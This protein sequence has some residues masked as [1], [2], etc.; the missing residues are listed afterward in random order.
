MKKYIRAIRWTLLVQIVCSFLFVLA[1]AFVPYLRKLLFDQY[2]RGF[3]FIL[4]L[5]G[6]YLLLIFASFLFQY[7]SQVYEWKVDYRFS[8]SL[9]QDFFRAVMRRP[10]PVF[11]KAEVG[12]YTSILNNDIRELES[13]YIE[14]IIDIIKSSIMLAVY[15]SVMLFLVDVRITLVIIAASVLSAFLPK[16]TASRLSVRK[17]ASQDA[18]G[19][20]TARFQDLLG[21]YKLYNKRTRHAMEQTHDDALLQSEQ[22]KLAFGKFNTFTNVLNAFVMN[23]VHISAFLCVGWLL[24]RGEITLGTGAATFGYIESFIYPIQYILNDI[25]YINA[26]RSLKEKVLAYIETP[27]KITHAKKKDF[28]SIRFEGVCVAYK[29]FS[30]ENFTYAFEKGKRYAIT[31]G[32]GS[33]KSTLVNSLMGYAPI[34][35]GSI[36]IDGIP[37]HDIDI[38]DLACF[39]DQGAHTFSDSFWNNTTVFRTYGNSLA[40]KMVAAL[41]GKYNLGILRD[42]SQKAQC[43]TLSGGEKQLICLVRSL[44]MERPVLVLDEAFSAID[45]K[46]VK[47]LHSYLEQRQDLTIIEITHDIS[48]ENLSRFDTVIEMK[49]GAI[50]RTYSVRQ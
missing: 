8:L 42:L 16:V 36:A 10:Y 41:C 3:G 47:C 4:F 14:A 37:L 12:E 26:S 25:N 34:D 20:Y 6:L 27:E 33:G 45:R 24:H 18:L 21:G 11:R 46:N 35:G 5:G 39:I 31:G 43:N 15:F 17:R 2:A 23:L 44:V 49:D 28:Q 13:L 1:L 32:S 50:A 30:I 38:E 9:K 29:D 22:K 7:I 40:E 48:V 19:R